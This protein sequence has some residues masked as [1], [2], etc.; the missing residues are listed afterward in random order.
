[1]LIALEFRGRV[2]MHVS[3]TLLNFLSQDIVFS[4]N[5]VDFPLIRVNMLFLQIFIKP[6]QVSTT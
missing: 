3:K 1:M 6:T 2:K 5:Q 4:M